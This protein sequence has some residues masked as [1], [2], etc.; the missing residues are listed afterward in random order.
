MLILSSN[1]A[2]PAGV[3]GSFATGLAK[4]KS[5]K[6]LCLAACRLQ[7]KGVGQLCAGPL[8]THPS[9]LVACGGDRFG[10]LGGL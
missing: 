6:S 10:E 3:E 8:A 4:N 2:D 1:L 5:L 9:P 7:N